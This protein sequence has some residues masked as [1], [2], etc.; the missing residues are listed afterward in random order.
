MKLLAILLC[1]AVFVF[2]STSLANANLVANG[3]LSTGDALLT[4]DT[5]TNL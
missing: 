2:G 5:D 1:A 3:L 4:W